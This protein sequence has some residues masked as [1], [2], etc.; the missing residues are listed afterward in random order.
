MTATETVYGTIASSTVAVTSALTGNYGSV[1]VENLATPINTGAETQIIWVRADG[2]AA[3][4]EADGAFAVMPG[5]TIVLDNGLA[6]WSQGLMNVPAGTVTVSNGTPAIVQP[7]GSSIAGGIANP[8]VSVSTIL[9]SGT[10]S[11]NFVVSSND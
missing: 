2:I 11:T 7:F 9:D 6:W 5:Q 4:K 8:G 1:T 3:V 10:T